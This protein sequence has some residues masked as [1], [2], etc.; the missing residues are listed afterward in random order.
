MPTLAE[1]VS[2][3]WRTF[4]RPP[5]P[6]TGEVAL[7]DPRRIWPGVTWLQYNPSILVTRQGLR[8]F[9][10]MRQ[11][12]QVKAAVAFK[13]HAVMASGWTVESPRDFAEDWEVTRFVDACLRNL[14]GTVEDDLL[15]ILG[16]LIYGFSVTEKVWAPAPPGDFAGKVW[17][18]ALKTRRPDSFLF[19]MD[20]FGN[21]KPDGVLQMQVGYA[22]KRLPRDRFVLY[23]HDMEFSNIYGRSDLEAAYRWWWAKDNVVKWFLM[24][25]ERHAVP[26]LFFEYDPARYTPEQVEQMK[27]VV[28]NWQAATHGLL[29]RPGGADALDIWSS[30]VQG[31]TQSE[32]VPALEHFDQAI[33]RA[34]LMPG[35]LGLTA[36]V[37]QGSYARAKVNFDVFML[38]VEK[39]RRDIEERV[40]AE[41]VVRPLVDANYV[42]DDYPRFQFIPLTEYDRKAMMDAWLAAVGA[43]VVRP[44]D[45][46][47]THIRE[48]LKFPPLADSTVPLPAAAKAEA[49]AAPVAAPGG[50]NGQGD[51]ATVTVPAEVAAAAKATATATKAIVA[52]P[53]RYDRATNYARIEA[54]LS[55]SEERTRQALV[56]LFRAVRDKLLATVERNF[57]PDNRKFITDLALSGFGDIQDTLRE[58]VRTLYR[59]GEGTAR[60]ELPRTFQGDVGFVPVEALRWLSQKVL[61]ISGVLSNRLLGQA[62]EVLLNALKIGEPQSD[63]M[64]KLH[65]IFEPYI[66]DPTLI[67][68]GDVVDPFRLET[69]L[70]TNATEAFNQ[71]RLVTARAPELAG[72]VRGMMYSAVIDDRTTEVCRFLDGKVFPL[73]EPELDR[74]TPPN[75]FNCR[76]VLVPVTVGVQVDEADLITPEQ[77]GRAEMLAAPGFK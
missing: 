35:H 23:S 21:L 30:P 72:F 18:G 59:L 3:A 29:P 40:M 64:H 73:D 31:R 56:P 5:T 42:V 54:G 11:D 24:Y 37:A 6:P 52:K 46:D 38:V 57:R 69:I 34:I 61:H 77:L 63:T 48:I 67:R 55:Q 26:G 43:G 15:E 20:E 50:G 44:Q 70:R 65:D 47:E 45:E 22:P 2:L 25:L 27:T 33:A 39:I 12:D 4:Q 1:R 76:S 8:V 66:G 19:D 7:A 58:F 17:Y 68:D 49:A 10:Q 28:T 51:A 62:R 60:A 36:D 53:Y 71:G 13:Q 16:A 32:F 75:H 14:E 41:Q 74:L 9:D